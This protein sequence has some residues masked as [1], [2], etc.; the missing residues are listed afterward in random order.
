MSSAAFTACKERYEQNA[1]D[2]TADV[3]AKSDA[4][5]GRGQ[6]DGTQQLTEEPH[7]EYPDCRQ[8]QCVEY[9]EDGNG[10]EHARSRKQDNVCA[11]HTRDRA[12]GADHWYI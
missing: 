7:A 8:A 9:D 6:R 11:E 10:D 4:G 3:G 12:A 1:S 5:T 2:E